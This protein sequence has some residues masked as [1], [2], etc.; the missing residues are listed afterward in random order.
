FL[1]GSLEVVAEWRGTIFEAPQTETSTFVPQAVDDIAAWLTSQLAARAGVAVSEI[2]VNQSFARYGIDSLAAIEMA[3]EVET[4]LGICVS[5]VSFLE[6]TSILQFASALHKESGSRSSVVDEIPVT[7][8]H[9]DTEDTE[10]AQRNPVA[11]KDYALSYGQRSLWFLYNMEPSSAAYNIASAVRIRS[12]LDVRAL[13]AALQSLIARHASL[14]TTFTS[15]QG[16]PIQRV[17]DFMEVCFTEEDAALWD[18]GVL[19]ERLDEAANRP[20]DL[21]HGPL[22]RVS[23]FKK[24]ETESILLLAVHHIVTDFWSLAILVQELGVLYRAET[25]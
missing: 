16:E 17:H 24:S 12:G 4:H 7:T 21:E 5:I 22:L 23:V 13:R 15:Q 11:I 6:S 14:R 19:N 2:D 20:F 1:A 18:E 25:A 3:H 10:L 9:R 8:H